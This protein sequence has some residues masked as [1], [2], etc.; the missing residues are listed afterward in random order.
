[1]SR[2]ETLPFDR[3]TTFYGLGNIPDL[4]LGAG[5]INL[6]GKEYVAEVQNRNIR[7]GFQNDTS[8]RRLTLRVVRNR[9]AIALLPKRL[10]RAAL[11]AANANYVLGTG[12]DG[13]VFQASDPILGVVDDQLPPAGVPPGDLFYVVVEGPVQ[14]ISPTTGSFSIASG[15]ILAAA[16]GT[17]AVSADAGFVSLLNTS[18]TTVAQLETRVGRAEANLAAPVTAISTPYAAVISRPLI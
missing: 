16:T 12:T 13:Y 9:S 15:A 2:D 8:G 3:G 4:S 11:G 17:S 6:E 10:V 1:M 5:G 18:S 14:V 7:L